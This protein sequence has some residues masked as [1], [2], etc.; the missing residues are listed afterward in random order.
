ME[1]GH[2]YVRVTSQ[3]KN[4][5]NYFLTQIK[6]SEDAQKGKLFCLL[7]INQKWMIAAQIGQLIIGALTKE[8]FNSS[9]NSDLVNFENSV[10]RVNE[11][12]SQIAQE[13]ETGWINNI[14]GA[15][16][17]IIDN[18]IHLST[19]GKAHALLS[20]DKKIIPLI[21]QKP[22][23]SHPLKTFEEIV[24]GNLENHDKVILATPDLF[25]YFSTNKFAELINNYSPFQGASNIIKIIKKNSIKGTNLI[26][27]ELL[28]LEELEKLPPEPNTL[29]QDQRAW[30][31][32]V[33]HLK[34]QGEN[35]KKISTKAYRKSLVA[36]KHIVSISKNKIFPQIKHGLIKSH[37]F[38]KTGYNKLKTN[39]L[40]KIIKPIT[41]LNEKTSASIAPDKKNVINNTNPT[42]NRLIGKTIYTV[43]DY[44]TYSKS[45]AFI[46]FSN[47]L[48]INNIKNFA[49]T[50]IKWVK[51]KNNRPKFYG[52]LAILLII[53][54]ITNISVLRRR[55]SQT[56]E[57]ITSSEQINEINNKYSQ[58]KI[59]LTYTNKDQAKSLLSQVIESSSSYIKNNPGDVEVN[60]IF[61]QAVENLD[62]LTSTKR[63][64]DATLISSLPNT[65]K[66]NKISVA[67][68]NIFSVDNSNNKIFTTN[69]VT[70]KTENYSSIPQSRGLFKDSIIN[71]NG[72][73][74]LLTA[75]GGM[76]L[77]KN[78]II[79]P[80][81]YTLNEGGWQ[82]ADLISIYNDNI[83]LLNSTE[84]QIYKYPKSNNGY[85]QKEIY[86]DPSQVDIKN[87]VSFTIDG[88][89][90][91]LKPDGSILK[92]SKGKV[93]NFS[94]S[95]IPTPNS[96]ITNPKRIWTKEDID[97]IYV[98]DSNRLLE[99]NKNGKFLK[100]IAFPIDLT[101]IDDF[102]I[103]TGSNK[104]YFLAQNKIY[105]S[106]L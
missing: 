5:N 91:A 88:Y 8:Y 58:A 42:E 100:Q 32:I 83:Y 84:G 82:S 40:S 49:K 33:L 96:K 26:I 53:I 68:D 11:V 75:S 98:L 47:N 106:T 20:R 101:A 27:L 99:L 31:K 24:S 30:D 21:E 105:Q 25:N 14:H 13:G 94:V 1:Y 17:L 85:S 52:L 51:V 80:D 45:K 28:L 60:N 70:G 62:L 77:I 102:Q 71:S 46:K 61:T 55:Q 81:E 41:A 86:L 12:L 64:N 19:T 34:K 63:L 23:D 78:P 73:P 56:K 48:Y 22:S 6:Q 104:I 89:I 15:L 38:L 7:E 50:F 76:Y 90:Y 39:N 36:S 67:K 79:A 97:I 43:N 72:Y 29:F 16:A 2:R 3:E 37:G 92:L 65:A 44:S 74:L 54:L 57:K 95:E 9:S 4:N 93:Q 35:A 66:V 10:K 103:D 69:I 59:A 87:S 18:Q